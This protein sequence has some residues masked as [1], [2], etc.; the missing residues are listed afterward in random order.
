MDGIDAVLC[1]HQKNQDQTL[2][3]IHLH[4]PRAIQA[5]LRTRVFHYDEKLADPMDTLSHMHWQVGEVFAKAATKLLQHAH[6]KKLLK[7]SEQKI[8]IGSHGQTVFHAPDEGRT[9]QIG[10][11]ASIVAA[12]GITT[13]SDFRVADVAA[14]GQGAPLVPWYHRRLVLNEAKQGV[15]VH[16]LGGISNFSYIGQKNGKEVLL[17]LD[18]GPANCLMDTAMQIL[19]HGRQRFDKGGALAKKGFVHLTLLEWLMHKPEIKKFRRLPAP[20]STGRELFSHELTLKFLERA[21]RQ[22][23]SRPDIL[24]T[25]TAFSAALM[26]EAYE[27]FVFTA[28]HKLK[29]IYVAGGGAR[30]QALLQTL[31]AHLPID[32]HVKSLQEKDIDP[33]ALEAQAFGYFAWCTLAGQSITQPSTTGCKSAQIS[34]K[35]SPGNNWS[36]LTRVVAGKTQ[37]LT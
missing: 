8:V 7:K 10:E 22:K 13:V 16:N 35:I 28:G 19:T 18:T 37:F 14:G 33:Q 32:T 24:A 15:A 20:K 12:T 29:N 1:K 27:R 9:W 23:L 31:Q 6:A 3:H 25:L 36:Q 17:A 11:A 21:E 4:Y 5:E 30:N 34:G 26:A 2:A